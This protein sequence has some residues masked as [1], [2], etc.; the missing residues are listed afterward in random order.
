MTGALDSLL[1]ALL[2]RGG[3]L[4]KEVTFNETS[5]IKY[6]TRETLG[7]AFNI[8]GQ[9]ETL[10]GHSSYLV[11]TITLSYDT[12]IENKGIIKKDNCF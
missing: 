3:H 9:C 1:A 7:G 4:T 10:S 12:N 2:I 11:K 6:Q 5:L 8:T